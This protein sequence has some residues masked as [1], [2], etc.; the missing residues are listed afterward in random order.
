MST[1]ADL[2]A[3]TERKDFMK[4]PCS[5]LTGFVTIPITRVRFLKS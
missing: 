1:M 3:S 2:Q 4:L 5:W